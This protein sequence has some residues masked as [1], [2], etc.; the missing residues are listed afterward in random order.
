MNVC[1]QKIPVLM[2]HEVSQDQH[3]E[4]TSYE[5]TPFYDIPVELFEKQMRKL[6]E[7]GYQSLLFEDVHRLEAS[8]KYVIITFDDGLKG[9][10]QYG[11]PILKKY[12]LRATFFVCV[13]SI[14]S[15]RFMK[16]TE[17]VQLIGN[18]M[19][20][21][22]HTMSHRPLHNLNDNDI[23]LELQ[24]S[25]RIIENKLKNNINAISLPHGSYSEGVLRIAA[26]EGYKFI[27]TSDFTSTY[28]DT[29]KNNPTVVGRIAITTKMSMNQFVK[30]L[31]YNAVELLKRRYAKQAKNT[32]KRIIGIEAYRKIYRYIFN[33]RVNH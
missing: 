30:C 23:S 22:S 16:W 28:Y 19:S 24:E 27:C 33:I 2:Y 12:G 3:T 6:V 21:Q 7:D 4:R 10:Y 5:M 18:G 20:V 8:K 17:L 14:G 29:F 1:N 11:L 26:Q 25:K 9:N 32:V 15:N 13:N 31:N